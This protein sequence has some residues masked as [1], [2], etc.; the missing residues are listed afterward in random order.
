MNFL[1][2]ISLIVTCR[3]SC[4]VESETFSGVQVGE[5]F[6]NL[7]EI[8]K[9]GR[10]NYEMHSIKTCEDENGDMMGL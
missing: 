8:E 5:P 10:D 2:L 1:N 6:S 4:V 3:A 7:L 9:L